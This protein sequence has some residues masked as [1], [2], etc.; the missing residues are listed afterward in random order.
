MSA[1]DNHADKLCGRRMSLVLGGNSS[2]T[3]RRL[4]A[5]SKTSLAYCAGEQQSYDHRYFTWLMT[6]KE[7]QL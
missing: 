2:A 1:D 5:R 3:G 4:E 7:A 6:K